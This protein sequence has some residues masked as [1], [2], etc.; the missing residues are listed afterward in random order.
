MCN[1]ITFFI[2]HSPTF[3]GYE[4]NV[5]F[6]VMDDDFNCSQ[7]LTDVTHRDL[8]CDRSVTLT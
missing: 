8:V 7:Y 1:Y 4:I 3:Q 2:S 6:S 5:G